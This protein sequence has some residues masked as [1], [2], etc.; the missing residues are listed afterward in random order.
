[1]RRLCQFGAAVSRSFRRIATTPAT[2]LS[3]R[4]FSTYLRRRLRLPLSPHDGANGAGLC[5][6]CNKFDCADVY[7]DSRLRPVGVAPP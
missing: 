5:E 2:D 6:G 7:G 4:D 1:M 3:N